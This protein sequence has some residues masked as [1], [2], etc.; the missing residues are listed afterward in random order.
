MPKTSC[1]QGVTDSRLTASPWSRCSGSRCTRTAGQ[2]GTPTPGASSEQRAR[3]ALVVVPR[4]GR[5]QL[6]AGVAR[7]PAEGLRPIWCK[8]PQGVFANGRSPNPS[9]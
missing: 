3:W 7:G 6:A 9:M 1:P 8:I 4:A 2:C 5:G